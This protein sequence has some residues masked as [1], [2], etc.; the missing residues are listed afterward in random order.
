MHYFIA[1]AMAWDVD[2][3]NVTTPKPKMNMTG[4]TSRAGLASRQNSTG[5]LL[6]RKYRAA[7]ITKPRTLAEKPPVSSRTRPRL[8]VATAKAAEAQKRPTDTSTWRAVLGAEVRPAR[9][10]T[11]WRTTNSSKG[12]V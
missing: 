11:Q 12:Y 7:G 9:E 10:N 3:K 5:V 2:A 6:T 1:L 4:R 8:L